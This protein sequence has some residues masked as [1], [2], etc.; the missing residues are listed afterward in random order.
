M[1]DA[2][3]RRYDARHL[4][5][6]IANNKNKKA[7]HVREI[8]SAFMVLV[9]HANVASGQDSA[10]QSYLASTRAIAA[11]FGKT[12]ALGQQCGVMLDGVS[13]ASTQLFLSRR[14]DESDLAPVLASYD[15]AVGLFSRTAC[16]RE[17]LS[18]EINRTDAFRRRFLQIS[19]PM[20]RI[21]IGPPPK[22]LF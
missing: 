12:W 16:D 6:C 9:L 18:A 20:P 3:A 7:R 17:A 2:P 21:E 8:A 1:G 15:E 14:L 13:R 19:P 4:N 5:R 11:A 10:R 22:P